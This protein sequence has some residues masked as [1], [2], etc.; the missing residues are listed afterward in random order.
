MSSAR[1]RQALLANLAH[2]SVDATLGHALGAQAPTQAQQQE[3]VAFE[4]GLSTAQAEVHGAGDLTG[5]E[6]ERRAAA[7][8]AQEFFHR[9]QRPLRTEPAGNGVHLD[10]L[11]SLEAWR[12]HPNPQRAAIVRGRTS[13]IP[14]LPISAELRPKVFNW[15]QTVPD[16]R[17]RVLAG[18]CHDSPN[19]A[20]HR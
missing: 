9:D 15:D 8:Q 4:M 1:L 20:E 13:S 17:R 10:R 6:R 12:Y 5:A 7:I 16:R 19:A 18:T 3:I 11:R 2:Q 14:D